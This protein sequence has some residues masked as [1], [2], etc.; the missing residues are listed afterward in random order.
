MGGCSLIMGWLWHQDLEK[1]VRAVL[2]AQLPGADPDAYL[3][4]TATEQSVEALQP[5]SLG[6]VPV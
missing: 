4:H 3:A 1:E 6:V 5:L 2:G